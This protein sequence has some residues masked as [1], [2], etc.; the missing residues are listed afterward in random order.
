MRQIL[1]SAMFA[2]GAALIVG[3]FGA[4]RIAAAE[5]ETNPSPAVRETGHR[6]SHHLFLSHRDSRPHIDGFQETMA[7]ELFMG[8]VRLR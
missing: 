5:S 6:M 4:A 8:P 3:I 1:L 2:A 7:D